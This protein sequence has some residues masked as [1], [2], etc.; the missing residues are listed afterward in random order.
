MESVSIADR[1]VMGG[2]MKIVRTHGEFLS[3]AGK[4]DVILYGAGWAGKI[5]CRYLQ[6]NGISVSAFM[7][8]EHPVEL[9]QEVG[10]VPL[11]SIGVIL[12][13]YAL[14]EICIVMAATEPNRIPMEGELGKRGI[15]S[16]IEYSDALFYEIMR[17]VRKL[18]AR[19]AQAAKAGNARQK[20]IGYLAPG[21][22]DMD[23]AERRL[24]VGKIDG[25]YYVAM[26]KETAWFPCIGTAY[27]DHL[28]MHRSLA[29][30]CYCPEEYVPEVDAIH[31]FNAV[32]R[33]DVPWCASFET[34]IPRVSG[35]NTMEEE[36]YFQRLIGCMKRPNCKK[37]YALSQNAYGIQESV[38]RGCVSPRD[39][40]LLMGKTKVLHPPQDILISEEAFERKHGRKFPHFIFVGGLFFI[41]GG[42]ELVE[43]LSEFEDTYEFKLTLISSF[44]YD[45]YF[46]K[47][48]YEEMA[49]CREM[50]RKKSW[51]DHYEV[52]PNE[53][54]LEKCREATVGVLASV[55]ETYGYAVLEMQAAGCPVIT[56]N[57]R[58]F[59]ENNNAGCGWICNL[60]VDGHGFCAEHDK[61]VWASILKKELRRCFRAIF[62]H[63]ELVREKGKLALEQIRRMH[64]PRRYR[65]ELE[66]DLFYTHERKDLLFRS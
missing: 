39:A 53:E 32:C 45:D 64:D 27:E 50:I 4:K 29:E 37:L 10:G 33:T 11:Y 5:V 13:R 51:I 46:T 56:T 41:K 14:A 38:L 42:K 62:D 65:M 52:L 19:E 22:L 24:I 44:L 1:A 34:A 40:E 7:V 28:E 47:T 18:D 12:E 35:L 54:V 23:Y 3:E 17:E 26:P 8:S 60:P 61:E 48:S 49:A 31:T 9:E 66:K 58:A 15:F 16:Y 55:A 20:T 21:Y 43:V 2:K 30:A 63:P 59:P 57:I 36:E 6:N 25:V